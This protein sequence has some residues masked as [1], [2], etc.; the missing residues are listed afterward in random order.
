MTCVSKEY[1]IKTMEQEQCLQLKML[2]L[3]GYKLKLLFSGWQGERNENLV[4]VTFMGGQEWANFRLVGGTP[5]YG[6]P[7]DELF[8]GLHDPA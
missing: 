4:G 8:L 6:K 2:F 3:L 1:E 7:F 5:Q